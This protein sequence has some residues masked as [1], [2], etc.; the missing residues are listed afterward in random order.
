MGYRLAPPSM[1]RVDPVMYDD[2]GEHRNS[3]ASATDW[4]V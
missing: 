1:S 2:I 4:G 3:K